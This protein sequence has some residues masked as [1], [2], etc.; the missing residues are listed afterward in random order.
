VFE[1][2]HRTEMTDLMNY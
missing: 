1:K 2:H